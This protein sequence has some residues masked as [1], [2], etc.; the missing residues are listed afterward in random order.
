MR[1]HAGAPPPV[2]ALWHGAAKVKLEVRKVTEVMFMGVRFKPDGETRKIE[3]R[4]VP[5]V[6]TNDGI[7]TRR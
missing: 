3:G 5:T 7:M 1:A 2:V 4:R 6:P